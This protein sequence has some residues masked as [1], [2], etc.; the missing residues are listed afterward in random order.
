MRV[1]LE[2][3]IWRE[4]MLPDDFLILANLTFGARNPLALVFDDSSCSSDSSNDSQDIDDDNEA[5]AH[6]VDPLEGMR[7]PRSWMPYLLRPRWWHAGEQ[8]QYI[9]RYCEE[10]E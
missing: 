6:F 2:L 10:L 8:S 9:T 4:I 7:L 3:R 1:L 5:F